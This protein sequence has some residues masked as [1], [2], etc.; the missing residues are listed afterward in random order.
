[1]GDNGKT[2]KA[3]KFKD[4]GKGRDNHRGKGSVWHELESQQNGL[5]EEN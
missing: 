4:V 5:L 2:K 3:R 1:M